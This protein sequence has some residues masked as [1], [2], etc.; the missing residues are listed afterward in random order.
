MSLS[1]SDLKLLVALKK[2]INAITP[3]LPDRAVIT[4]GQYTLDSLLDSPSLQEEGITDL[5]RVHH[6]K[7]LEHKTVEIDPE[8]SIEV[9]TLYEPHYWFDL[10]ENLDSDSFEEHVNK[11]IYDYHD[12]ILTLVNVSEGSSSGLFPILHKILAEKGKNALGVAVFP[13]MG[14]SS[15]ALFNAF[16]SVGMMNL[17]NSAPVLLLDQ[18]KLEDF[19]GVHREGEPLRDMEVIDYM[20]ELLLDKR[21]FVRDIYKISKNF[22]IKTFSALM[23]T[24]CSLGIYE[25]FR[26]ILEITLEQPLMD[27]DISTATMIYVLVKAPIYYRDELTKGDIEFEV[28]QWL[29]DSL[30]VDIPQICEPIFVDEFG[31]RIDIMI[32]VGGFDTKKIYGDIYRRIERFS[33]MNLEQGLYDKELWEKIKKELLG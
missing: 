14:H 33:N 19:S 11:R 31:D 15:D 24:G 6:K 17:N 28:S 8:Y 30:G 7:D 10:Q 27:F 1:E 16:A 21:G 25:N 2:H 22:N 13:S 20:V 26:N 12:E 18:G 4:V 23:A 9:D 29:M 5:I 32:L 3:D